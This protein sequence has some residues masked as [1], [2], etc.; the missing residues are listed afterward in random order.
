M[1][2]SVNLKH[3]LSHAGSSAGSDAGQSS[4]K[5]DRPPKKKRNARKSP[6]TNAVTSE[7]KRLAQ[8]MPGPLFN[9]TEFEEMLSKTPRNSLMQQ[10]WEDLRTAFKS[11]NS[12]YAERVRDFEEFTVD[13]EGKEVVKEKA[14]LSLWKRTVQFYQCLPTDILGIEYHLTTGKRNGN[15][16]FATIIPYPDCPYWFNAYFHVAF[17]KLLF[18]DLWF[19]H[20]AALAMTLQFSVIIRTKEK[21]RWPLLNETDDAFMKTLVHVIEEDR[22]KAELLGDIVRAPTTMPEYCEAA[23]DAHDG[24][25]R[26]TRYSR[27]FREI[28]KQHTEMQSKKG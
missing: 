4:G 3:P 18:V 25:A 24:A 6:T 5:P 13:K 10:Q 17:S 22:P 26:E 11:D 8:Y 20:P 28:K 2:S 1:A 19:G 9:N 27:F 7:T 16:H 12:E 23:R 14:L 21:K 15:A